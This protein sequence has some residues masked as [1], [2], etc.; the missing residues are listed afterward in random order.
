MNRTSYAIASTVGL[1]ISPIGGVCVL[2]AG[3]VI[4]GTIL[5]ARKSAQILVVSAGI[6][7][8]LQFLYGFV[9][10]PARELSG[11]EVLAQISG[12]DDTMW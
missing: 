10:S 3:S 8:T 6:I 7:S 12:G 11:I 5:G 1:V 2:G 9:S 4:A